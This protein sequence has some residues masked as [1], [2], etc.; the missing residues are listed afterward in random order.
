MYD[1]IGGI[2]SGSRTSIENNQKVVLGYAVKSMVL[3]KGFLIA[4][5]ICLVGP[6]FAAMQGNPGEPTGKNQ[7][8]LNGIAP[9]TN[10]WPFLN[11]TE[12]SGGL[13]VM[14]ITPVI[15]NATWAST[16]GGTATFTTTNAEGFY[17]GTPQ[18]GWL[19]Q[20]QNIVPSGYNVNA[21]VS[22][23][24][25]GVS[26]NSTRITLTV[27]SGAAITLGSNLVADPG[28]TTPGNAQGVP[29]GTRII[30]QT[31]GTT[32]GSGVYVTNNPTTTSGDY[33]I[34]TNA[35]IQHVRLSHGHEPRGGRVPS[36]G[37]SNSDASAFHCC[38]A[39][40]LTSIGV[41]P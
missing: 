13:F 6:S 4:A 40:M 33:L 39:T 28:S 35:C 8:G 18:P 38:Q 26:S 12:I 36:G 37:W 27:N 30:S 5:I 25:N 23:G 24:V 41:L 22:K 1:R 19:V 7:L 17:A 32:G 15:S 2:P 21:T 14:G 9:Y 16:N 31:S 20:T 34:T 29:N 3:A 11:L 10:I